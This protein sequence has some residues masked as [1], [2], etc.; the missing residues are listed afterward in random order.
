MA[1]G[2]SRP[3]PRE[4]AAPIRVS[5]TET[6]EGNNWRRLTELDGAPSESDIDLLEGIG[7][8]LEAS[9]ASTATP[10]MWVS[11]DGFV[12][13]GI[14]IWHHEE[15]FRDGLDLFGPVDADLANGKDKFILHYGPESWQAVIITTTLAQRIRNCDNKSEAQV[16]FRMYLMCL[17]K[18][19]Q[20][21][22]INDDNCDAYLEPLSNRNRDYYRIP[23]L[24][25]RYAFFE[26][27]GKSTGFL[28]SCIAGT[29]Y[30]I[31]ARTAIESTKGYVTPGVAIR[32]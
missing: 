1:V 4:L 6:Q 2:L 5:P 13:Q 26:N 11:P 31:D 10:H 24:D 3:V 28:V 22:A 32:P 15:T 30:A 16:Y 14:G 25:V 18:D 7:K 23:K 9:T 21:A 12:H 8:E 27:K 19:D 29:P 20:F 17:G